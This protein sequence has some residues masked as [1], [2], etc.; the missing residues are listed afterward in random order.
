MQTRRGLLRM[1]ALAGFSALIPR[2][3]AADILFT[4]WTMQVYEMSRSTPQGALYGG[5][6]TWSGSPN[7]MVIGGGGNSAWSVQGGGIMQAWAQGYSTSS[8]YYEEIL[9]VNVVCTRT[10]STGDPT[11]SSLHVEANCGLSASCGYIS[12]NEWT[13]TA[14]W[15]VTHVSGYGMDEKKTKSYQIPYGWV[16]ATSGTGNGHIYLPP[17]SS[18][19]SS[20]TFAG[21]TFR[22]RSNI[23]AGRCPPSPTLTSLV[24][25]NGQFAMVMS[26][27]SPQGFT[28]MPL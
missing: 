19:G 18:S 8:T 21:V 2:A 5:T 13:S 22:L 10:A 27:H 11:P 3:R 7:A 6:G 15:E 23:S 4:D 16:I 1:A 17:S 25:V 14:A 28:A 9:V 20:V 26:Q 24:S 12:S